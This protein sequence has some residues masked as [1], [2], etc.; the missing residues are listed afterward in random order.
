MGLEYEGTSYHGFALQPNLRTVQG[1]LEEALRRVL[2]HDVRVT[3][4]GRTDSGVHARGQV[5]SFSTEARLPDAAIAR[6]VN[7]FL[8]CD[9]VAADSVEVSQGF[10]ARRC[11]LRRSYRY[12]IWRGQRRDVWQRR[13]ST[14]VPDPLDVDA[15]RA[16]AERLTGQHDFTSF[17]GHASQQRAGGSPVRRVTTAEWSI[18]GS[19]LHFDCAADAFARH[20]VRNMVGTLLSVGRRRRSPDGMREILWARDRRVAGPTAPARG[21]TLM[22]VD[23]ENQESHS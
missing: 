23:Y 8:P 2:G 16:A 4:A 20:M 18:D 10:D 19:L 22:S 17:I 12:T 1:A 7:T 3:A 13:F 15:M 9:I 21:L 14:H 6:A 5:V 11:A